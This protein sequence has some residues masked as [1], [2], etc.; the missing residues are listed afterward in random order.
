MLRLRDIMTTNVITLDP[1]ATVRQA[2]ELFA[3]RRI[4]G[5]PV[6]AGA[7]VVGVI[8]ASDLVQ[9]AATLPGRSTDRDTTPDAHPDAFADFS[10]DDDREASLSDSNEDDDPTALYFTE[11]WDNDDA[12]IVGRIETS[13]GGDWGALDEHTVS[14]AM[15]PAPAHAL[16][17][18]TAVTVAAEY[19]R[20]HRIHR[21]L[22]MVGLTL[23]GLVSSSDIMAAVADGKLTSRTFVFERSTRHGIRDW[24]GGRR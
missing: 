7:D 14:E 13:S 9:F 24:F 18:E 12:S 3:S 11:S 20:D 10:T 22:V 5:A 8:S 21:V 6:V 15:T 16:T 17:P 2:M 1:D 23:L 19:M 4:S